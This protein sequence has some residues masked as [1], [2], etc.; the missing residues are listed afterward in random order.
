LA[1]SGKS[2]FSTKKLCRHAS[3]DSRSRY[4]KS[5]NLGKTGSESQIKQTGSLELEQTD[6]YQYWK[7]NQ[8]VR[9]LNSNSNPMEAQLLNDHPQSL[10]IISIISKKEDAE[11]NKIPSHPQSLEVSFKFK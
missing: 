1:T 11:K 10:E 9:R 6:D 3:E 2:H 5:N 8:S 4:S 7:Y